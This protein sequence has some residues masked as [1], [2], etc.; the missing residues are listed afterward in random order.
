[1]SYWFLPSTD[2]APQRYREQEEKVN[3]L[4][5]ETVRAIIKNTNDIA[6]FKEEVSR[7]LRELR[8]FVEAD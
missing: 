7:H 6:L 4:R 8:E 1:V 5:E 2:T 3:R